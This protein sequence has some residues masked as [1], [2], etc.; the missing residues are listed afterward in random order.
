MPRTL[1]VQNIKQ[2]WNKPAALPQS[3]CGEKKN[4]IHNHLQRCEP[5]E[6]GESIGQTKD[7]CF[8]CSPA[9]PRQPACSCPRKGVCTLRW[10]CLTS[11]SPNLG[12]FLYWERWRDQCPLCPEGTAP[13]SDK[14]WST[15][16]EA[17]RRVGL[18]R[19]RGRIKRGVFEPKRL[20]CGAIK[21][22][23]TGN[24]GVVSLFKA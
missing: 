16:R 15:L 19:Y 9:L 14:D 21:S 11:Y 2:T 18:G 13:S 5:L 8:L 24:T 12:S 23:R 17:H 7:P 22:V 4:R 20:E 6:T 3:V 10:Q 1:Q